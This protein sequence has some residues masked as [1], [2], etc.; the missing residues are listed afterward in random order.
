MQ[1]RCS[2]PGEARRI[3]GV[4]G[5]AYPQAELRNYHSATFPTGDPAEIGPDEVAAVCTLGLR[6]APYLPLRTFEDRE[7]DASVGSAQ[8]DPMLG[9]L[10]ALS[11]LPVDWRAVVQLLF[12]N[13]AWTRVR[14]YEDERNARS[15]LVGADRGG[16]NMVVEASEVVPDDDDRGRL[17]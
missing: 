14:R 3:A 2:A 7:I 6:S 13:E 16:R 9:V 12:V 5:S 1:S 10:A 8:A 4:I 15:Q 11:G 17:P